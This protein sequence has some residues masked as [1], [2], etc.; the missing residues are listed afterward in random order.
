MKLSSKLLSLAIVPALSLSL[1]ACK[2]G[3]STSDTFSALPAGKAIYASIDMARISKE[4]ALLE[5]FAEQ[6][7]KA[8]A[9]FGVKLADANQVV[10]ALDADASPEKGVSIIELKSAVGN[11]ETI[12]AKLA[13]T[14]PTLNLVHVPAGDKHL[15][16]SGPGVSVESINAALSAKQSPLSESQKAVLAQV[17][18]GALVWAVGNIPADQ[19]ATMPVKPTAAAISIN[20]SGKNADVKASALFAT[21]DEAKGALTMAQGGF[22]GMKGMAPP[23]FKA[24]VDSVKF[25]QSGNAVTVTAT[26][27][28][29]LAKSANLPL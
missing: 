3:G 27:P 19:V 10:V 13:E 20:A 26:I 21:A 2:K 14:N 17:D 28:Q 7:K 9:E 24:A 16:A 8:E 25:S 5:Q 18:T 4:P 23:E 6:I 22:E 29:D 11:L 1:V 15:Y 12:K